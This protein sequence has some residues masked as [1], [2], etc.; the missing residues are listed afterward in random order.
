[1]NNRKSVLGFTLI[2][3]MVVVAIIGILAAAGAVAYNHYISRAH[4]ADLI[5]LYDG[6][7]Q[8]TVL[9]ADDQGINLCADPDLSLVSTNN[10]TSSF[11]DLSIV[12]TDLNYAKPLGLHFNADVAKHGA[13]DTDIVREAYNTLNGSGMVAPGAVV[14]NSAVSFTALLVESPCGATTVATQ[15]PTATATTTTQQP[16]TTS[17]SPTTT[18][19]SPQSTATIVKLP[20]APVSKP[21]SMRPDTPARS[22]PE[23]KAAAHNLAQALAQPMSPMNAIHKAIALTAKIPDAEKT[24]GIPGSNA[25]NL[26]SDCKFD[27]VPTN[28]D[29]NGNTID[30]CADTF[31][32]NC[33][34]DF[35]DMGGDCFVAQ[36]CMKTFNYC[37][38]VTPE[39]KQILDP[40][41]QSVYSN[42]QWQSQ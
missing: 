14:T 12:K 6:L 39:M 15:Q 23:A 18:T 28:Q 36:Y 27:Q 3:M 22:S 31:L 5:E 1:M 32:G 21:D 37:T 8:R 7:R 30:V 25:D 19:T 41:I 38:S 10:L 2:E 17:Q 24:A 33:A 13:G 34:I 40:A 26:P 35:E 20:P 16:T 4:S 42:M 29:A 9:T 11:A